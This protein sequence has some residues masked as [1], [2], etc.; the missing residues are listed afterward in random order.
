MNATSELALDPKPAPLSHETPI[1]SVRNL[2][3]HFLSRRGGRPI[4]AVD[5]VSFDLPKGGTLGIVGESGS[6]KSVTALSILKL[7]PKSAQMVGGSILFEGE[8]LATASDA[9]M[10]SL[11]GPKLS[12]ILQDPM[13]SL[14]PLFPIGQQIAEPLRIHRR[15]SAGDARSRSIELLRAVGIPSPETRL[16]QYPHEMSGGMLQRIVAATAIA[17]HPTLLIAD[18]PTTALD[19]TVQA[20]FLDLLDDLRNR[21]ALSLIIITHDFGVVARLCD[22][23]MVM[24]AGRTVESGSAR[25]IF[26]N[27][28]HPY[29]IALLAALRSSTDKSRARLA[30][31]EGAPPDLADLPQGCA[32]APR[33]PRAHDRCQL[34]S[35]P[36]Y[37]ISTAHTVACWDA[38]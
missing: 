23:V 2:Q 4:R 3:T 31:I 7:L 18:E 15:L 24:Y 29:T 35:P 30:G 38:P 25:T 6:G 13:S 14:D 16:G 26:E 17:C 22:R 11:R 20:Q 36:V 33:C 9:R 32:F 5:G 21:E 1:L 19:P 27:P 8:D 28:Q 12:M 10:R 34:E 37:G